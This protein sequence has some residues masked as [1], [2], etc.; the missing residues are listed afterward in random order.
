MFLVINR[1]ETSQFQNLLYQLVITFITNI[2]ITTSR[3]SCVRWYN[4]IVYTSFF[5]LIFHFKKKTIFFCLETKKKRN[6]FIS[7]QKDDW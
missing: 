6:N 1:A 2:V 5:E 4:A 3:M 7:Q